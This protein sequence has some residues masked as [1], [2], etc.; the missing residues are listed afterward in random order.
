MKSIDE[1]TLS[2]T[3]IVTIDGSMRE[4]MDVSIIEAGDSTAPAMNIIVDISKL[5]KMRSWTIRFFADLFDRCQQQDKILILAG[6]RCE[7]REVLE[8]DP[9]LA[10]IPTAISVTSA[11][12]MLVQRERKSDG[13]VL[14]SASTEGRRE[15]DVD[16]PTF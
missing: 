15:R 14:P 1:G 2:N 6:A 12:R 3:Y 8:I 16:Y 13:S 11:M 9:R 10:L 7:A 5:A 4:E